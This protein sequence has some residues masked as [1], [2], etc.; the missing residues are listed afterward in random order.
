M[1]ISMQLQRVPHNI[2]SLKQICNGLFRV[3][4]VFYSLITHQQVCRALHRGKQNLFAKINL[5]ITWNA[6]F[7][8]ECE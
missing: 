8:S 4:L 1:G 3:T 2:H 7:V 5:P 6:A